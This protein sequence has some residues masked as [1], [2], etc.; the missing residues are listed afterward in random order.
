[1]ELLHSSLCSLSSNHLPTLST[2]SNP[3]IP[4]HVSTTVASERRRFGIRQNAQ[5][6]FLSSPETDI[7]ATPAKAAATN[8]WSLTEGDGDEEEEEKISTAAKEQVTLLRALDR[9]WN[10]IETDRWIVFVAFGSLIIAALSEISIPRILTE[11]VFCAQNGDATVFFRNSKHLALLCVTSGICSGLRSGCFGIA[12]IL[13]VKRLRE[14]LYSVVIVQDISF[15]DRESVGDL[16]SRLG[17]DC[18]RLSLVIANDINLILRNGLQGTGALI[19]LLILSWPLALSALVICSVLSVYFLLYSK[20]RKKASKLT[21]DFTAGANEVAQ[22]TLSMMRT[23]RVSGTERKEIGRFKGWLDK[24]AFINIRESMAHGFWGMSFISLYRSMQIIAVVLGG[25]SIMSGRVSPEQ[26]TKYVLYCEW[27]IYATWRVTD[28]L[29]SL[30]QSVGAS[31]KVLQLMD[32]LPSDQ[33]VSTGVKLQKV[34]GHI[35]FVNV[36]F[37]YPSR[38]KIPILEDI[39]ISIQSNKVVA[40]VG[41]SGSGKSTLVNLLLRLYEPTNGQINIDGFPISELDIRWLRGKIGF[42]AQ[43]PNLFH[44]SIK[45]N[46]Q[47]GCCE[48]IELEDIKSAAKQA[49]AHKFISSLPDGYE[50]V[51]DD[52][53]LSGGQKQ[54]IALARAILRK[55]AILILDEA[56][57]ALDFEAEHH[58]KG[59]L[60]AMRNDVKARRTIIVIAHRLSTIEAADRIIVMDRGRVTEIGVHDELLKKDG[61]YANLIRAQSDAL[62]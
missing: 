60:H 40:I 6:R 41:L 1:M 35:Q 15:F 52:N 24:V 37:H 32:L 48:D 19:N 44:M 59:V 13:L 27:L 42:V 34:I 14:T 17:S 26:L 30:V 36:S 61:M 18:Q 33:F 22:E 28:N 47:Y 54:R 58:I 51:V 23:V 62:A 21:Q 7:I 10:L 8:W 9:M 56:T 20:Y 53:L 50:T 12:N 45:S 5:R 39:S 46:I 55:P 25:I 49:Y 11:S 29:S 2:K 57:S 16:T 38:E 4:I 31:E 3:R 43:E